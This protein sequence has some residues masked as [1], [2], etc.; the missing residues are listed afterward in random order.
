[1]EM[2]LEMSKGN[3]HEYSHAWAVIQDLFSIR[4][5]TDIRATRRNTGKSEILKPG[6]S[7]I[8]AI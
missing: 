2:A 1:M 3:N 4:Y 8:S 6:V 7:S 5:G